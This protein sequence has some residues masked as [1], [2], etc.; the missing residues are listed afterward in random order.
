MASAT[1]KNK[2][3][4]GDICGEVLMDQRFQLPLKNSKMFR[5]NTAKLL[6]TGFELENFSKSLN[7]YLS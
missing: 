2:T 7:T 4:V 5:D 1:V 6:Q 3:T